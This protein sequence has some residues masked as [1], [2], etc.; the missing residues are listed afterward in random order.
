MRAG[1]A[2]SSS[3]SRPSRVQTSTSGRP[4]SS[5]SATT[6]AGTGSSASRLASMPAPSASSVK[7]HAGL[8]NMLPEVWKEKRTD[9]AATSNTRRSGVF[10]DGLVS[11][12]RSYYTK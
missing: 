12:R 9:A 6:G 11:T 4:S 3:S 8:R 7:D 1:G 2:G 10:I 5:R